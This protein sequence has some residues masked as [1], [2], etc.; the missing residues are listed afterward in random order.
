[1]VSGA[2]GRA[3]A[4]SMRHVGQGKGLGR[5]AKVLTTRSEEYRPSRR[6][7]DSRTHGQPVIHQ[8]V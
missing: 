8:K 2:I 6:V 3:L 1:M 4:S 7:V 5:V